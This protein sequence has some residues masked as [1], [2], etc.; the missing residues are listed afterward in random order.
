MQKR[1]KVKPNSKQQK[2]EELADGSLIVYLKS[3]PVD[4]KANEELIKLLAKKFDVSKSS[5]RIKSGTT[6]RQKVIEIDGI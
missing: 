6:S 1:V 4:G 2:I 3:P 5:I